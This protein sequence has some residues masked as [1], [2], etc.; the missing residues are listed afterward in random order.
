MTELTEREKQ[1]LRR[2]ID[3]S[4]RSRQ[5]GNHPF[6]AIF[7]DGSGNVLVEAENSVVTTG[8]LIGHAE[9]NLAREMGLALTAEQIADGTVYASCEPCAMC[10]G[11]MYWAGVNRLI[12]GM[13]ESDLMVFDNGERDENATMTGVGCR[14]VL[15]SGQ[16]HIEVSGPHLV[17]EAVQVHHGFW[18]D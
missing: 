12:Y 11:A 18:G 7:V 1:L 10:A 13:N 8:D 17:D 9:T 16:R 2:A 4:R 15:A 5:N 6:G 3:V 14:A